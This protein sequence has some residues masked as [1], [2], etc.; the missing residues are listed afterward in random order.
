MMKMLPR[1]TEL[2]ISPLSLSAKSDSL[3]CAFSNSIARSMSGL[4]VAKEWEIDGKK[5]H[6]PQR[7]G[8]V[9]FGSPGWNL[10]PRDMVQNLSTIIANIDRP[11][12]RK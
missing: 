6:Q 2:L 3:G 11:E 5:K 7:S 1:L 12:L 4:S 10:W 9:R 8:I